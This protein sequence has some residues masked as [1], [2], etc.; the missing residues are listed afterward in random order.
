MVV[1]ED[2]LIVITEV[3]APVI[4]VGLKTTETPVGW[5]VADREIAESNP[6][7]TVLVILEV[8]ELPCDT[9]TVA[10]EAEMLKLGEGAP[11]SAAIRAAPFGLPIPVAKS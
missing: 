4:D 8:P 1:V 7:V 10:G 3:P 2:T 11:E 9:E 5:P 6:P